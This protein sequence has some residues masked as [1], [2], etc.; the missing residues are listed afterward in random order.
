MKKI[1]LHRKYHSTLFIFPVFLPLAELLPWLLTII[2]AAAALLQVL[3]R[4]LWQ[5]KRN[6]RIILVISILCLTSAGFLT[7]KRMLYTPSAAEGSQAIPHEALSHLDTFSTVFNAPNNNPH[8]PFSL[9]W[10]SPSTNQN[11]GKPVVTQNM[12][13]LGT[14]NN[15]IDAF[16]IADGHH[17]WTLHKHEQVFSTPAIASNMAF[18]GEG[19]HTSPASV[20]TAFSLP[21]GTPLWERKFRSHLESSPVIDPAHDRLWMS[22]GETGL[23]GLNMTT[24]DVLWWAE[25]GHSDI[26]PLFQNNRLFAAAKLRE[27]EDGSALIE[28][29]PDTGKVL[30][31]TA[32]SGDPMCNLL[33]LPNGG[34]VMATAIGQVGVKR[35]T[36]AGWAHG[37]DA[38]GEQVWTTQLPAMPLPEGT[39]LADGSL[40]IYT[41]ND[42]SLIALRTVDGI[43]AWQKKVGAA[44]QTD[45]ALMENSSKSLLAAVTSEGL[46]TIRNAR[47]G[48]EIQHFSIEK[49][50]SYPLYSGGTL[51]I[52]T[53]YN[54]RAYAGIAP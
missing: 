32:I 27:D 46:V 11:I 51:Y 1:P 12:I 26:P 20:L 41:L 6:R 7:Y 15:T 47:T 45:V 42:G 21:N 34:M 38:E 35:L 37:F 28:L 10:M 23:W 36:D 40:L 54:I 50:D 17:I 33:P 4:S 19:H 5:H 16:S 39:L 48:E 22:T 30:H 29:N 25:I 31:S 49:G 24:G 52:S 9:L 53:P 43:I 18:V 13:M 14:Y 44:F 3:S 8:Q 2:G